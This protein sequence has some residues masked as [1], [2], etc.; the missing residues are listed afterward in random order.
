MLLSLK[1]TVD[2]NK[3]SDVFLTVMLN[4]EAVRLQT[5]RKV[6]LKPV[7]TLLRKKKRWGCFEC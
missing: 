4:V 1:K 5:K 2:G 3:F 7:A 6:N